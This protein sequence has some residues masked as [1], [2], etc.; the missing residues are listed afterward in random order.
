MIGR[1]RG[2]FRDERGLSLAELL[3]VVMIMGIIMLIIYSSTDSFIR[4]NDVTQGKS[5]S[6]ANAR[7]AL[8]RATK[9]IRAANPIRVQSPVPLYDTRITFDVYCSQAGVG[10]CNSQN[11]RPVRIE[12]VGN[13][14]LQTVGTST[15]TLVGPEGPASVPIAKRRGAVVNT[16]PVFRSYDRQGVIIPTSGPQAAPGTKFRDCTRRVEILL[17][18]VSEHRRPASTIQ[19]TTEVDLRNFHRIST[20]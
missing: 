15:F 1:I 17:S 19:L 7:T 5:F 18:V 20:C 3:V 14:L 12:L 9:E 8:E 4:I 2:L 6:L 11:L 16:T 13:A 10:S